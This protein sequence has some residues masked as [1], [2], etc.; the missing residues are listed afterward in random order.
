MIL[1]PGLM[2]FDLA[3]SVAL[4]ATGSINGVGT[5]AVFG[6]FAAF[7]FALDSVQRS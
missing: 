2:L 7:C 6:W 3:V 1:I 5:M 4:W